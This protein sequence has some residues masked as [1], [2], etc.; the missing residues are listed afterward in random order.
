ME[1]VPLTA[2]PQTPNLTVDTHFV[3]VGFGGQVVSGQLGGGK[4][5]M[6]GG[7]VLIDRPS[8]PT[9]RVLETRVSAAMTHLPFLNDLNS[10]HV[11]HDHC[12]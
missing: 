7:T 10:I 9:T 3:C 2:P 4:Q 8:W 6:E 1:H 12:F 11:L 5:G